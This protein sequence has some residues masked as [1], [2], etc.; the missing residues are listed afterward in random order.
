M[1]ADRRRILK[2]LTS[3]TA[4]LAPVYEGAV[5][6][7]LDPEFPGRVRFV[8]HAV[9]EIWNRL[10][11]E[12]APPSG[13]SRAD[14]S[15]LIDELA[16]R[17]EKEGLPP[18]YQPTYSDQSVSGHFLKAVAELLEGRRNAIH[19]RDRKT[20]L[21]FGGMNEDEPTKYN[22]G[23]WTAVHDWAVS[24]VHVGL[25]PTKSNDEESLIEHFRVFEEALTVIMDR[26][27]EPKDGT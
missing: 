22:V 12:I 23:R 10:P 27:Y 17:W 4:A 24:L 2:W 9:R 5:K 26:H 13:A 14:Y 3:E 18:D 1:D 7:A 16:V 6:M 15:R 20:Q 21:L 11:D 8:T 19:N 25:K